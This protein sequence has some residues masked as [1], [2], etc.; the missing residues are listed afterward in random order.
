MLNTLVDY[1]KK[2]LERTTRYTEDEIPEGYGI[3]L[4]KFDAWFGFKVTDDMSMRITVQTID[5]FSNGE[6]QNTIVDANPSKGLLMGTQKPSQTSIIK[7]VHPNKNYIS[8][9]GKVG[10]KHAQDGIPVLAKIEDLNKINYI[11]FVLFNHGLNINRDFYF[12]VAVNMSDVN[13]FATLHFTDM[14]YFNTEYLND[15]AKTDRLVENIRLRTF[16]N[17]GKGSANTVDYR[18]TYYSDIPAILKEKR[19]SNPYYKEGKNKNY[20]LTSPAIS[21]YMSDDDDIID[22]DNLFLGLE[23]PPIEE[24]A[25]GENNIINIQGSPH[26]M[27]LL[28]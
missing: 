24:A 5:S 7:R 3:L 16:I 25:D 19:D 20:W 2:T 23:F 6:F 12:P 21:F 28:C 11:K 1:K 13:R 15:A 9:I 8:L 17:V 14:T 10:R 26:P 18:W 27:V 22:P 4:L